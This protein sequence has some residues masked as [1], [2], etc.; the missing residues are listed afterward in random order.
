MWCA[1]T[2]VRSHDCRELGPAADDELWVLLRG[3][4][5]LQQRGLSAAQERMSERMASA[6]PGCRV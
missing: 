5:A 2:S 4:G 6:R 3:V 1:S